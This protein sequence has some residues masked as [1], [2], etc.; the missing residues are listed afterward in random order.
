MSEANVNLVKEMYAA[1]G[2]GQIDR[3]VQTCVPDV[4]WEMVGRPTDYPGFGK[5]T[6]H[7]GVLEFF[8]TVAD[9]LEFSEFTP[10]EFYPCGDKVFVLGQYAMTVKKTGQPFRS[11]WIHV[12][13]IQN[14]R[15]VSFREFTDTAQAAEAW[16]G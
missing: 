9:N 13:T 12:F 8:G 6:G 1:F 5:R 4:E 15:V 10:R 2:Q 11:E 14:G 16:R 3:I 7:T